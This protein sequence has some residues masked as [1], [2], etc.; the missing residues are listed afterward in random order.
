[1]RLCDAGRPDPAVEIS[2]D[3]GNMYFRPWHPIDRHNLPHLRA[4]SAAWSDLNAEGE[5]PQMFAVRIR[6]LTEIAFIAAL[7][8]Q[9]SWAKDL[10]ITI[11]MPSELTPVQ[12]LNRDGVDAVKKHEYGKAEALFQKA[13]LYDPSD[14]FTLNN[15][16]YVAELEG[17]LDRAETFYKLSAKQRSNADIN[18]SS[19]K[20]LEGKPMADTFDRLQNVAMRVNQLNVEA[21]ELL[22]QG[23]VMEANARLVQALSLAPK[24]AFTLNNLGVAHEAMGDYDNALRYYDAA[25]RTRSQQ[26]VILTLKGGWEGRPVSEMAAD[27]ARR[28]ETRM[29]QMSKAEV[30]AKMLTVQGVAAVN[31]NNWQEAKKDFLQAYSLDPTSGFS[32]NNRGY[33]AEREG[34]LETAQYF[35]TKARSAVD[36]DALVGLATDHGAQ[37]KQ[38][39]A[40]A[41][42]SDDKVGGE[43]ARYSQARHSQ[44]GPIQLIPRDAEPESPSSPPQQTAPSGPPSPESP[45]SKP[46]APR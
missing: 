19:M 12:R 23:R 25:A 41:N 35:Y 22:S 11:P 45:P 7:G 21:T 4:D 36:A 9:G 5:R 8:L 39:S 28:L 32:L 29:E 44:A 34:D 27:S 31:Q 15:L 30:R 1:M 16:G 26:P 46:Q 33:V 13:Y 38:V 42:G 6:V 2:L 43:L 20:Q 24:N 40:V 10:K 17:K 3:T 14:P 18:I 37:G